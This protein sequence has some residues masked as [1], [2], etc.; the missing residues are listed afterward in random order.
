MRSC[1]RRLR[2][3][4]GERAP[5]LV[6][7]FA[8]FTALGLAAAAAAI[9]IVVRHSD[10]V[11]A[12]RAAIARARL[13]AEAVL[14]GQ[15]HASDLVGPVS[16]ERRL[17][18]QRLFR[19]RVLRDDID[20][21]TLYSSR[22]LVTFST[23]PGLVGERTSSPER[24]EEALAGSVVSHVGRDTA[25]DG[26]ARKVLQ[27]YV[28]LVVRP[29]TVEGAIALEQ[30]Y[31]PIAA[32]VDETFLPIAGVLQAVLVILFAVLVPVL[33]RVSARIRR[34]V[35][36]LEHVATHDDLTGLENRR[37][38][39]KDA[40]ASL[41]TA[42]AGES[43]AV[44]VMDVERLREINDALGSANGDAVLVEAAERLRAELPI[45]CASRVGGD[46]FGFVVRA[47]SREA[48]IEKAR[49]ARYVL[50]Q[51]Y[52]VDGIRLSIDASAGIAL[53]PDHGTDVDALLRHAEL[54]MRLAKERLSDVEVY[55]P[56][57]DSGDVARLALMTEFREGLG[58][59]QLVVHYQPQLLVSSG[60]I[61]GVEALVRWQHPTRG[62][63]GPGAFVPL[64]ERSGLVKQLGRSVLET[65]ARDHQRWRALGIELEASVNVAAVDLLDLALPA[66]VADV[67]ERYSVPAGSLVLEITESSLVG[68]AAR[69][70]EVLNR[71]NELGV[72]IAI[73]DFGTGYSS[74]AYL[75]RLPVHELKIDRS[76]L[77]GVPHD[78][79]NAAIVRSTVELA[80]GLGLAVV[81]EGVETA[82]QL[83][84]LEKIGCDVA[85][86]YLVARPM[87]AD[88]LRDRL[89]AERTND[90]AA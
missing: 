63:L 37:G 68:D 58:T 67:L 57:G 4:R 33:A 60:R 9:L 82:E 74:L 75:R 41:A 64:V 39:T 26:S 11:Q 83:A 10:T 76:F 20:A 56:A 27:T 48:V 65:A 16:K 66:D 6:L 2:V 49:R 73:D 88:D 32:A 42:S 53:A 23:E 55:D 70:T 28:P 8:V 13:T 1:P 43:V 47:G 44:V 84:F 34:H 38:F 86:G 46:E 3:Q 77:A 81:A 7:R 59:G 18:L 50:T 25:R 21:A 22:G 54:A 12:E 87:P 51:P 29:G 36:E 80:R 40:S 72:R 5:R 14:Y 31:A 89:A 85:Q 69:T 71:L 79:A 45:D 61:R 17:T 19:E 30:D 90:L 62:L 78:R 24:L 15:L 52:V 35:E